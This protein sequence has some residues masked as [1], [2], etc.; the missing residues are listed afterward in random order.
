VYYVARDSDTF[1]RFD[2]TASFTA[3]ASWSQIAMS[4][5][6]GAAALD[7]AYAGISFDGRYLYYCTLNSDTFIRYD[8][9]RSFTGITSWQQIAMSSAQGGAAVDVGYQGVT[10]DGRYMYYAGS[11]SNT[12]IRFD[13][14]LAFTAI[15]SWQQVALS[16]SLGAASPG[17]VFQG[18]AFD[19][20]HI[21]YVPRGTS[22]MIR[23]FANGTSVPSPT[24]YAQVSS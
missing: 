9:T 13:T 11:S 6:Q 14:T 16:S 17:N 22:T 24:E 10:F 4:S 19:G 7:T 23:F 15:A 18:L 5:A 20:H 1:I 3:I 8:S 21:Y 12:Q 2:T